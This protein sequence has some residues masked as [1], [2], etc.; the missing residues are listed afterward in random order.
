MALKIVAG[1]GFSKLGQSLV[2]A[3]AQAGSEPI[4]AVEAMGRAYVEFAL[5][6]PAHFQAM[7]RADAVPLDHYPEARKHEDE[8]FGKLLEGIDKAFFQA[9]GR[10]QTNNRYRL[11]GDGARF[12]NTHPGRKPRA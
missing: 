8:A 7:F 3:A 6:H 12:G 11:L 4:K 10:G 2:R 1:E 9:T 5:R